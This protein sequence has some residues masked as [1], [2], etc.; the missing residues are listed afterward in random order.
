MKLRA[1]FNGGPEDGR[2]WEVDPA[3]YEMRFAMLQDFVLAQT[4][5]VAIHDTAPAIKTAHYR[6]TPQ[7]KEYW[8]VGI[9]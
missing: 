7:T 2:T 4:E 5:A 6:Y 9:W 3:A 8:F 1:K